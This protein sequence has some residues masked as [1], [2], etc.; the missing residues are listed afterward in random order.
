MKVNT[1]VAADALEKYDFDENAAM[2]YILNEREKEEEKI[3]KKKEKER[4]KIEKKEEEVKAKEE[5]ALQKKKS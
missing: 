4:K 5:I 2:D 1:N 3:A